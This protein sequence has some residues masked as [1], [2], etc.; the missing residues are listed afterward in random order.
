MGGVRGG[1]VVR[2]VCV[3]TCE[4]TKQERRL[5]LVD[6]WDRKEGRNG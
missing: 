1:V 6:S 2:C 4:Q 3:H 5:A